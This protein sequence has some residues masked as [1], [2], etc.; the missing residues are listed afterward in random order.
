M[1][2]KGPRTTETGLHKTPICRQEYPDNPYLLR[3]LSLSDILVIDW[4]LDGPKEVG[5]FAV[6]VLAFRLGAARR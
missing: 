5:T 2:R 6:Q 1:R 4:L 3:Q